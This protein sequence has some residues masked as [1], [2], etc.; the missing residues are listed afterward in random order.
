MTSA[1]VTTITGADHEA[2]RE[3]LQHGV[4]ENMQVSRDKIIT[5]KQILCSFTIRK[6]SQSIISIV[7]SMLNQIRKNIF[8]VICKRAVFNKIK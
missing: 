7:V 2:E 5:T 4:F 1:M 3:A 6:C 8:H